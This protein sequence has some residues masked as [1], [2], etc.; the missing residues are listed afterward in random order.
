MS[1]QNDQLCAW[2][3]QLQQRWLKVYPEGAGFEQLLSLIAQYQQRVRPTAAH[4]AWSERDVLMISYG[5]SLVS[6]ERS[7]LQTLTQF[8]KEHLTDTISAVH[9]LPC[10]PF[11]SDDGFAVID[12]RQVNYKLGDWADVRELA[13]HVELMMDLVLNHLSRQHLWFID[14]VNGH[15]HGAEYFITA[16]PQADYSAVVRP[17]TSPLIVDVYT[18]QGIKHVWATFS[19]DQIDLDYSN[20]AVLLE[21]LDVLL[22]YVEQGARYIRLDAVGFLWKT[23]G[24]SCI[25]LWQ[26][27]EV[28]KIIRETLM[29]VEP[30]SIVITETNVPHQE[31]ISYFGDGD[32]AHMVY[33]F[34][35][36]P[37]VLHGLNRGN[38]SYLTRWAHSL[39]ALP[40]GCT[41][42]NFV[43]SHDGIGVRAVEGLIPAH[44]IDDL[45][46]SVHDFGG[47]V[48]M[49]SN[50]DGTRSPYE[51]NISLFDAMQGTRTGPDVFQIPRFL[52]S[53]IIML[54]LRGIPGIYIHSLTATPNDLHNVE[55]TGRTR[56]INR[57][58]WELSELQTLLDDPRSNQTRVFDA[59]RR[60]IRIRRQHPAFH[61]EA[62]QQVLVLADTQFALIRQSLDGTE[63]ILAI[64]NMTAH[65]QPIGSVEKI[66]MVFMERAL[67]LISGAELTHLETFEL[68]PYQCLWLRVS[69]AVL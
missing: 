11:S 8:V 12:Y 44:E 50:G 53:Q 58:Q 64:H 59:Y 49:K 27:H 26:T 13:N 30:S 45:I 57:H 68:Q 67:D 29:A 46:K 35:L 66:P 34:A 1:Q 18:R 63:A 23:L 10:F 32:E 16:D 42:F 36:P 5:D 9:L 21:M 2:Q 38:A 31:N 43:A 47:F 61:P 41:F 28:V 51:L 20:P 56:S 17:R 4:E 25:H 54:S 60:L 22:G 39:A 19:D 55:R 48:S 69:G 65:P 6:D 40:A 3:Q 7:P 52:C 24:T 33:N 37:L 14:F 62:P 15:G